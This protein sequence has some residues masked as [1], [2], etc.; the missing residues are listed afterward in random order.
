MDVDVIVFI[1][2]SVSWK[3]DFEFVK[4]IKQHKKVITIASGDVLL[5]NGKEIL[6]NNNFLDA[7]LLDFTT[8]DILKYLK[9]DIP[10]N[11]IYRKN[12]DI[13]E[14]EIERDSLEF[15]I[16]IPR[17]N[18]FPIKKY[19]YPFVKKEPFATVLTDYGCP[20]KC[21]FCIIGSLGFKLRKVENVIDELKFLNSLRINEIYFADQ[22]FAANK[23][24]TIRLLNEMKKFKIGWVCFSRVDILNYEILLKMK[25][26]GCHTI[27]FGI[28]SFNEDVLKKH[29]KK[30]SKEK[31]F[32]IF[33]LCKE[34]GIRTVGIFII[35]L[36]GEDKKSVKLTID[37]VLN[38]NCDFTSFNLVIP[39]VKTRLRD[40]AIKKNWT[41]S[42]IFEM[43]Q[44][45]SFS[46]MKTDN[47]SKDDILRLHRIAYKKFYFRF[48]YILNRVLKIRS[49]SEL[50]IQLR[51]G[52][53][54]FKRLRK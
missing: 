8:N 29:G 37:N 48:S 28:E 25:E 7:I 15:E 18:L 1:T 13:V 44:S 24:R 17:H 54:L 53:A 36:P 32:S 14:G 27:M 52:I 30:I 2:G 22:T 50:K 41:S 23:E 5:D 39:R 42:N 49:I 3:I 11:M 16:P 10:K 40:E 38:L 45:G 26:A 34:I 9:K 35:A 20:F 43:D 21:S 6:K 31:T 33:K 46:V 19:R 4:K 47:L 12:N 51:E